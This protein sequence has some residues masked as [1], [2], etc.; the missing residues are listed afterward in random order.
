MAA[1]EVSHYKTPLDAA[2]WLFSGDA[3]GCKVSHRVAGFGQMQ[4]LA[5]PGQP[6]AFRLV[7]DW[8]PLDDK[9]ITARTVAP[10]WHD[11]RSG[12]VTSMSAQAYIATESQ[13]A[14]QFLEALERGNA[15]QLIVFQAEIPLYQIDSSPLATQAAAN[16]LRQCRRNL[17]P[18]PFSY[19][20]QRE[21]RF[22]QGSDE[23]DEQ[24]LKDIRAIGAYV[25]ADKGV[26][27][28]LVDGHTDS[29]GDHLVN[30]MLSKQRSDEIA[31]RLIE[32]GVSR[33]K[34]QVR[35]HGAR[36]PKASNAT[37]SG[38]LANRRVSVRLVKEVQ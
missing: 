29:S 18:Q 12:L 20:R 37:E 19:V 34:I 26:S 22:P 14:E 33:D 28:V 17:L 23:L 7:A 4:L 21:F 38:R 24:A 8:L 31:A 5:L 13:H 10:A 9:R 32:L 2:E 16:A 15:W 25:L 36:Y 27:Q 11:S 1:Q 30:L 3:F 6:L 35:S